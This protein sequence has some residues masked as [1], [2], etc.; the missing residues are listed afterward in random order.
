MRPYANMFL[1]LL[2]QCV[3]TLPKLQKNLLALVQVN[4]RDIKIRLSCIDFLGED[5]RATHFKQNAPLW[6]K[7]ILAL[8]RLTN[9]MREFK[10]SQKENHA[11]KNLGLLN[12]ITAKELSEIDKPS[13]AGP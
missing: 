7:R 1:L 9:L 2:S 6:A 11:K 12:F 8:S 3:D 5:K 4:E 13:R 10:A